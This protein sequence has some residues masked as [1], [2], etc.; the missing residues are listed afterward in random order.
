MVSGPRLPPSALPRRHLIEAAVRQAGVLLVL[1][2][3]VGG[4][5]A[6]AFS[7]DVL[8]KAQGCHLRGHE[9]ILALGQAKEPNHSWNLGL[10]T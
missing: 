8:P 9:G 2:P 10:N 3:H 1:R 4:R 6:V 5:E 7:I